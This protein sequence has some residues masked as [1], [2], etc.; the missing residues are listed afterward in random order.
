LP[1]SVRFNDKAE[2]VARQLLA[3]GHRVSADLRS[4]KIGAKIRDATLKKIPYMLVLGER[5][6][7]TGTVA[8]RDRIQGD[9]GAVPIAEFSARLR[10]LVKIKG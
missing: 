5:E 1:I 2:H 4:E 6:A 10:E 9:T 7:E 8:V 3:D